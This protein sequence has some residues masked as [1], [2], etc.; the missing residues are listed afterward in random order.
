MTIPNAERAY[1]PS[2][3]IARYLLAPG[4]PV[5][6]SKARFFHAHG[7]SEERA[8]D[9]ER[10]LLAIARGGEAA[11]MEGPHGTKYVAEGTLRTPRGTLVHVR[12]VWIVEPDDLRPRLVTAYPV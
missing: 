10:G 11:V 5:G 6:G 7:Y 9:L 1:V 3:K 2:E 12:T 8:T 4:H